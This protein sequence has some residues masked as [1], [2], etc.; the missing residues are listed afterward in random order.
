M[1]YLKAYM[2]ALQSQSFES[3]LKWVY[4]TGQSRVLF[5]LLLLLSAIGVYLYDYIFN[6]P[7]IMEEEIIDPN[8][9]WV[10]DLIYYLNFAVLGVICL[11]GLA[12]AISEFKYNV[13]FIT[14]LVL[15]F[16]YSA[17]YYA[18]L[19]FNATVIPYLLIITSAIILILPQQ[20]KRRSR[21]RS[22]SDSHSISYSKSNPRSARKIE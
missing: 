13:I 22:R 5:S 18:D 19:L 7:I 16:I 17:I 15:V 6:A 1:N 3:L 8:W 21:R 20:A 9:T 12:W 10:D 14:Q 2:T 4:K 11:N